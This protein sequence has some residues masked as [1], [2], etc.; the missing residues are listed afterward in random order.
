MTFGEHLDELRSRLFRAL[1]VVAALFIGGWALAQKQLIW[2]FMQ[3][4]RRAVANLA[5]QDPPVEVAAEEVVIVG[6]V[7]WKG[8]RI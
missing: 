2:L 5:E 8:G 6:R 7:V 4:H 1:F 3:P